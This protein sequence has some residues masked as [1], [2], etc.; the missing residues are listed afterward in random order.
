MGEAQTPARALSGGTQASCSVS[1]TQFS[2]ENNGD[3]DASIG[4]VLCSCW[5][6]LGWH[7]LMPAPCPGQRAHARSATCCTGCQQYYME[8]G[9]AN[10]LQD[11]HTDGIPSDSCHPRGPCQSSRNSSGPQ[12]DLGRQDAA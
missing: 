11:K 3:N 6:G 10:Q 1:L 4:M 2:P 12:V 7:T 9:T 5:H 8:V